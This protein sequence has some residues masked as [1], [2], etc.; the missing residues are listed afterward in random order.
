ML[1]LLLTLAQ[2]MQMKMGIVRGPLLAIE[3]TALTVEAEGKPVRCRYD[4][5][6]WMERDGQRIAAAALVPGDRLEMV[7]D[8][9]D[10]GCYVR[11]IHVLDIPSQAPGPGRRPSMKR[12][13]S[14]P[15]EQF[16]PRGDITATG[17]VTDIDDKWLT[18]RTRNDG[19]KKFLLRHDTR[20]VGDGFRVDHDTLRAGKRVFVRAGH[21][22]E[23]VIEA[24]Q[25]IWGEIMKP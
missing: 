8:L 1:L 10:A 16:A 7:T 13:Y 17:L 19:P 23:G 5:R 11:T 12:E 14:S 4:A 25:V 15:T 20:Y 9:K 18:I 6:T 21:N 3:K 2:M 22:F 24:Y